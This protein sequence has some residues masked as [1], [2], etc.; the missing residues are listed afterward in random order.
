MSEYLVQRLVTSADGCPSLFIHSIHVIELYEKGEA[1]EKMSSLRGKKK[2][3]K[4]I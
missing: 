2:K 4:N 1:K 3:K